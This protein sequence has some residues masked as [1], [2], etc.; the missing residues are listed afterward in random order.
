MD[1]NAVRNVLGLA[2]ATV[3]HKE[4]KTTPETETHQAEQWTVSRIDCDL[5]WKQLPTFY[6]IIF[7][8][9]ISILCCFK[10]LNRQ[11]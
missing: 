4:E 10:C 1:R 6:L 11:N 5:L 3:R 7:K 8:K 9:K 2:G